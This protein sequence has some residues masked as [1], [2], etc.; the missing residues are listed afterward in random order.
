[1]QRRVIALA[2]SIDDYKEKYNSVFR[3]SINNYD[4]LITVVPDNEGRFDADKQTDLL[5]IREAFERAL[6]IYFRPRFFHLY[7]L[8]RF[9]SIEVK[10]FGTSDEKTAEMRLANRSIGD[11]YPFNACND[12]DSQPSDQ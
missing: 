10:F 11:T 5:E 2:E 12:P 4:Q 1:M 6:Y 7:R 3:K 8:L 9:Q